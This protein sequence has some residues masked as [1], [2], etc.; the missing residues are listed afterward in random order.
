MNNWGK[1]SIENYSVV[2]IEFT[3]L[4]FAIERKGIAVADKQAT[5]DMSAASII[6]KYGIETNCRR[7]VVAAF[8]NM[9]QM[10]PKIPPIIDAIIP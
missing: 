8:I 10:Y 4:I 7:F 1:V 2:S 3:I 6:D 9:V 5:M